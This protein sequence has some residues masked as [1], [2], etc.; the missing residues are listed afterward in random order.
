MLKTCLIHIGTPKTGTSSLQATLYAARKELLKNNINYFNFTENHNLLVPVFESAA[1]NAAHLMSPDLK[2]GQKVK[3]A[4]LKAIK[5]NKA[6]TFVISGEAISMLTKEGVQNLKS[7]LEP[8]FD[9]FKIVAYVREPFG[10]ASSAAQQL[11]KSGSFSERFV[12]NTISRA[13]PGWGNVLPFYQ[14]RI[15]YFLDIFGTENTI[16]KDFTRP[17]LKNQNIIDDFLL[18]ILNYSGN[19]KKIKKINKNEAL[20]GDLVRILEQVNINLPALINEKRN[21]DRSSKLIQRL[22]NYSRSIEKKKYVPAKLDLDAFCKVIEKDV[23]WLDQACN[24]T[25]SLDKP[26]WK[27]EPIDP[28]KIAKLVNHLSLALDNQIGKQGKVQASY[29]KLQGKYEALHEEYTKLKDEYKKSRAK[30]TPL[31]GKYTKLQSNYAKSK[32]NYTSIHGKYGALQ[33]NYAASKEKHTD[34]LEK[35]IDLQSNYTKSKSNYT[36][37]HRKY[38]ELQSNFAKSISNYTSIHEKFRDLQTSHNTLNQR[39]ALLSQRILIAKGNGD[40]DC[41]LYTSP[42]PRDKRQSRM[43]S[44]A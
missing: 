23:E 42:S 22:R 27:D 1:V 5:T 21:T 8:Y 39:H 7:F 31:H 37:I 18:S 15:E 28:G 32:S 34:L 16:V 3:S 43:P 24:V 20:D 12:E 6:E 33:E 13:N 30:I 29:S 38:T 17:K 14:R 40:K 4:L 41:L 25:F 35:Y 11:I 9:D 26:N 10:F 2:S 44:S 19:L 36:S